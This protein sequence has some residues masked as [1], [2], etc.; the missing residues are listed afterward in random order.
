MNRWPAAG[1]LRR[2]VGDALARRF[3]VDPRALAALRISVG[4]LLLADLALR[5]RHLV[6]FYTDAGVLPR[7]VLREQYPA[8]ASVSL[9][10]V[11]GSAWVQALLFLVAGATAVALAL[12]YRTRLATVAS[13]VL[14]VS[15][16]ARNPAVLN[17]GDSILRRLLFWGV[18]L[19]L[20]GRWSV[21]ALRTES[22]DARRTD[23]GPGHGLV[24]T[25]AS[26][27]LLVQV[28]L[29]YATNGLFKLRGDRWLSGDGARIALGL[30]ALTTSLGSAL[31]EFPLVEVFDWLWLGLLLTAVLLVALTGWARAVFAGLFVAMHLGM[32]ATLHLG[33]FPFVSIAGLLTFVPPRFWDA[34]ERLRETRRLDFGRGLRLV[35]RVLPGPWR[36]GIPKPLSQWIHRAATTAKPPVV[37]SLL[38]LVLVWNAATLGYVALPDDVSSSVDPEEYR[39]DMFAP[40]P[41]S[42]DGWYVVPGEL[43][44]GETR[45]AFRG[46][47]VRWDRPPNVAA[48]YPGV[49]WYKYLVDLQRG[50]ADTLGPHFAD[51]L[52]RQWNGT[53]ET[54]MERLTVYYVEQT[55]E[56]DGTEP[57]ERVELLGYSCS[58]GVSAS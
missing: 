45:D 12:G 54:E 2:Q 41:R 19:P 38:A 3:G 13:F 9:H 23:A 40:E 18:F 27:A 11:S 34:A 7:A 17:A 56:L 55:V 53:H 29:V 52:C 47:A 14:L 44:S 31:A 43:A 26:A 5:A 28:V 1:R 4:L 25:V 32:A 33:V 21:D 48:T 6:A 39:W 58:A 20:G 10:A 30:D 8:F 36:V 51:Y 57:T 24:A 35:D 50:Q 42:D 16:H 22:A 37:G 46:G 15:L 49:R